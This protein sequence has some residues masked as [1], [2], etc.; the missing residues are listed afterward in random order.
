MQINAFS[1]A[2]FQSGGWGL[3]TLAK[4]NA[5]ILYGVKVKGFF[6]AKDEFVACQAINYLV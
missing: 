1:D 3:T 5:D 2:S 4:R 6:M